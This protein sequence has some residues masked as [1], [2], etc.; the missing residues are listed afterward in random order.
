MRSAA[1][2]G[3]TRSSSRPRRRSAR[4]VSQPTRRCDSCWPRLAPAAMP[5]GP[6]GQGHPAASERPTLRPGCDRIRQR[7]FARAALSVPGWPRCW[8]APSAA[9][10]ASPADRLIAEHAQADLGSGSGISRRTDGPTAS[11]TC[12]SRWRSRWLRVSSTP[13]TAVRVSRTCCAK[14]RMLLAEQALEMLKSARYWFSQLTLIH[15]LTLLNLSE[16]KQ[17]WD[18]Y[19]ARPE[20][21]VQHWLDVAGR[22]RPDRERADRNRAP[23]SSTGRTRSSARRRCSASWRSRPS[24]HNAICGSTRRRRRPGRLPEPQPDGAAAS[25]PAVDPAVGGLERAQRASPAARRRRAAAAQSRRSRRPAARPRTSPA[26]LE[27]RRPA[28][29]H[30]SLTGKRLSLASPSAQPW[31]SSPA[32]AASTAASSSCAPIRRRA[33]CREWR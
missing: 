22:E 19:G 7:G 25:S 3:P 5:S 15:A 26:P 17:P 31:R 32:S 1:P 2:T 27:P 30:H 24:E 12:P 10:A 11:R 14:S 21:I 8:S 13:P 4:A 18:K 6:T 33:G 9:G 20:A 29:V 23:G 16:T 28:A